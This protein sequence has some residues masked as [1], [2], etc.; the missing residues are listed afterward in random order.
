LRDKKIAELSEK[1]NSFLEVLK[2]KQVKFNR[3]LKLKEEEVNNLVN[4]NDID[5][6]E[7]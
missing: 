1:R 7:E 2:A 5:K 3:K 4:L 6:Y